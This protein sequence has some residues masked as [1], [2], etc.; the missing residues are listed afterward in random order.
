MPTKLDTEVEAVWPYISESIDKLVACLDGLDRDDLNWSP[1]QGANSLYVLA[2][3][4]VAS[5][6]ETILEVLCGTPVGRLR[7]EEFLAEGDSPDSIKAHW[8]ESKELLFEALR[9]TSAAD[10]DREYDHPRLGRFTGREI[11]LLV[12]R[13]AGEHLGHAEL[14]LDL[15]KSRESG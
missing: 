9:G 2:T 14:T 6:R 13:H 3:H 1:L 12:I 4:V 5:C 7:E 11:L 8:A 10:L 15:L